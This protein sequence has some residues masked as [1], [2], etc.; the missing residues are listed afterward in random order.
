MSKARPIKHGL[1]TKEPRWPANWNIPLRLAK[2][3]NQSQDIPEIYKS[4]KLF[5]DHLG[6]CN[7]WKDKTLLTRWATSKSW[8]YFQCCTSSLPS[9]GTFRL[10]GTNLFKCSSS[11]L[12][13]SSIQKR[14]VIQMT[15]R[16]EEAV[17]QRG[18]WPLNVLP[19]RQRD[20]LL[21]SKGITFLLG[22]REVTVNAWWHSAKWQELP[23]EWIP[24]TS[25]WK[26]T[27]QGRAPA[28]S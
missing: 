26:R 1:F 15:V 20:I 11:V 28:Q 23:E 8:N 2:K 24:Q 3:I 4:Q 13:R 6:N 10:K 27:S 7:F 25:S 18:C 12:Y 14:K 9:A 21:E 19:K 22:I 17:G 5:Q 16:A